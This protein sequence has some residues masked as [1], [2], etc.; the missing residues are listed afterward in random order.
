MQ[1]R[2]V[3]GGNLF[4][5]ISVSIIHGGQWGQNNKNKNFE[6]SH[7]KYQRRLSTAA[8]NFPR[9]WRE[10]QFESHQF[11]KPSQNQNQNTNTNLNNPNIESYY[12][13][14][15]MIIGPVWINY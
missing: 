2:D 14:T 10:S 9:A 3:D 6:S 15:L 12:I 13:I 7:F 4:W 11:G 8:T 5:T 1:E